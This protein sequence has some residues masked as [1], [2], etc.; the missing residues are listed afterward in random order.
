MT[1]IRTHY[2]N[3]KV[4]RNAPASV[5]KAAYKALCQTYHPDK[6]QG[7][8]EEAERIMKIIN[9]SYT[10]LIDSA[11]RAEH[12]LW[13]KKKTHENVNVNKDDFSENH[14]QKKE[15]DK[16][17]YDSKIFTH[18]KRLNIPRNAT[19]SDIRRAYHKVLSDMPKDNYINERLIHRSY[20]VLS[21]PIERAKYDAFL[22]E[23]E[24]L[25]S[26]Q[27]HK[28]KPDAQQKYS[29]TPRQE[30]NRPAYPWWYKWVIIVILIGLAGIKYKE[31][32]AIPHQVQTTPPSINH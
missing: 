3:L 2:D 25:R 31:K 26:Q 20:S 10:V 28:Q 22:A 9:A 13:I 32:T 6:F 27:W 15:N 4:A 18:Y 16:E 17:E 14:Q 8:K 19:D 1:N 21:N 30:V 11:Q 23:Q 5:I 24:A 29:R 7:S 12:D